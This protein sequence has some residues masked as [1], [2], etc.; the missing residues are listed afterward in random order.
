MELLNT[1][2]LKDGV[3]PKDVA[4]YLQAVALIYPT[5]CKEIEILIKAA[6]N[7]AARARIKALADRAPTCPLLTERGAAL[8]REISRRVNSTL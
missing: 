1:A 2:A 5:T 3:K 6:P 4:A 8:I 7:R